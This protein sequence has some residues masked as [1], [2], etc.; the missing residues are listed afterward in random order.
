MADIVDAAM[1]LRAAQPELWDV[2]LA[3]MKDYAD[4]QKDN[5]L[6][7]DPQ[8][9]ERAQGMAMAAHEL[10]RTLRDAP[11]ITEARQQKMMRKHHA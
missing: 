7:C 8:M 5:M 6:G 4:E 9:L 10:E 11:R 2:F 3:A 1:M